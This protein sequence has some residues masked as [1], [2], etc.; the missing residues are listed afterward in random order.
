MMLKKSLF[1]LLGLC[2][3]ISSCSKKQ[4]NT[5]NVFSF[6]STKSQAKPWTRWWWMGSAVDSVNLKQNLIDLH[7]VGI[8][9]VEIAPIYGVK[10]EEDNFI[11]YLS[12]D[13]MR[14]LSY[15][16]KIADSL[17]MAVDLTLGTGWPYGGPQVTQEFAATKLI[18]QK[19]TVKKGTTFNQEISVNEPKDKKTAVLNSVLAFGENGVYKELTSFVKNN[20]IQF[21]AKDDNYTLYFVFTGKTRQQV[22]R[23]A[24]GAKGFT[25]DHYSEEALQKYVTPFDEAFKNFDG[26]IRSIFN[27]SYEVYGTDFTPNF[28]EA[29]KKYRGYDL[30]PHL[31]LLLNS[32]E[33]E[34]GNRV[35]GDYR[36]T[37]SDLLLY[38]FDKPWTEWANN[39]GFM[40]RLQ[41]HGS[42]GNL[43]DFYASADIPECETFGSMPYDIN[44]FRREKED[45]REGDADP[46]MLKFSS[47]AAHIAGKP[48]T[49]SE[50]FTWLRDHFKTALSQTKPEVEDLFLNGINHIFLHGT[51]YSPKRAVWPGWKFYAS[52]N[53]NPNLGLGEDENALFRYIENCQKLLQS[54]NPDNET[55]LYWPIFD[56]LNSHLKGQLF[57]QFKI[58]SLDEWLH[59]QPFYLT[60]KSLLQKGYGVDFVSDNFIENAKVKNGEIILPGG[61]YK[62]LIIPTLKNIPF[63]TAKKLIELKNQ[64]AKIIFQ[65]IPKTVPGFKDYKIKTEELKKLFN[66]NN[67]SKSKDIFSELST[68]NIEPETLVKTGLKYIRRDING[69]KIYYIVNH[70]THDI[71]KFIPINTKSELIEIFNPNLSTSGIAQ[72]KKVNNKTMV[73]VQLKSGESLF[74]KTTN[75]TNLKNWEYFK[76]ETISYPITGKWNVTFLKGGPE[77]PSNQTITNLKSWTSFNENSANFSGTAKYEITFLNPKE[78]QSNWLLKLGDVRESAK[79]WIN[80][81]FVGTLWSNPFEINIGELKKGKNKLTLEVTNLAANRIRAKEMRGEEWKNFYEINMVN[82]DYQKFDAT[83][84]SPMPSG[85]L[86]PVSITP[87]KE[88]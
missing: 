1:I 74:L 58:H 73:K 47:S 13:W 36:Q 9:G 64:G 19:Y 82:K 10:G 59:N 42:P 41:A 56:V 81:K 3:F 21:E 86:G 69:D 57:F 87:L 20:T 78:N 46:V 7:N 23:A 80:N 35:K 22:K 60:T 39:N 77:L 43:I 75:S 68:A 67:I 24:P 18:T 88:N 37:L 31:P 15:T 5:K 14:M 52:V 85:I 50:T 49:S 29:F 55:L 12:P 16:T 28:F 40:S 70:T 30:K 53:F 72:S 48:L 66:L 63:A 44:G 45:I 33:T 61:N 84:W 8:G 71:D 6:K 11:D 32:E 17:G 79:V 4:E 34:E 83:K 51:T 25:L 26:K 76:E 54:G 65:D 62:S 2:I 38:R 27:D